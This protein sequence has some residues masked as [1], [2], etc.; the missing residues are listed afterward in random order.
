MFRP[1]QAFV[2]LQKTKSNFR[3]LQNVIPNGFLCPMV[4][5]NA[6]GHGAIEITKAIESEGAKHVGVVMVEEGI[7]LRNAG[8]KLGILIFSRLTEASAKAL[9]ENRLTPVVSTWEDLSLL[10]DLKAKVSVHVKINT[11][12]NRMG[13]ELTEI[14]KL[15]DFF[16]TSTVKFEG[17][18]THLSHG[19]DA[20][21][22]A[23]RSSKQIE[24]FQ[25]IYKTF[26]NPKPV[27]HVLNSD[28]LLV[29]NK[30][31]LECDS[32]GAR[33][34]LALYGLCE[35]GL[36]QPTMSLLTKVDLIR[37]VKK[38][39]S[40]SYGGRWTASKDS[41]IGVVPIGYGDGYWRAF[42]NKSSMLYRGHRV[43]VVGSVCMDYSLLDLTTAT[44]QGEP[45]L[46]EEIVVFGSQLSESISVME[47][48][49]L[50]NT[51]PYE[52]V[53]GLSLRVPRTY[54]R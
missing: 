3:N 35:P 42:S 28:A 41:W 16:A 4:K 29:R 31:G 18:L 32:L 37:K 47:L 36:V 50:V 26:A 34:G 48:T 19:F 21:D 10:D 24:Q 49:S 9:I 8:I 11:G 27:P 5:A 30:A 7:E 22:P 20:N 25:Q 1:T 23:G 33:P 53:T 6:Y 15:K 38:G 51:I 39:E 40:V 46:G 52:L 45:K 14:P 43:P 44:E 2:D 12:M 17:L 54:K 13:F